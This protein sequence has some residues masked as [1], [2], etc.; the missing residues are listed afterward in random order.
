MTLGSSHAADHDHPMTLVEHL[1]ELRA[2]LI[3]TMFAAPHALRP[4][5]WDRAVTVLALLG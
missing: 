2:R 1:H 3:K 5:R 4:A